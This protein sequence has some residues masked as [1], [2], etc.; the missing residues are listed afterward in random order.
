MTIGKAGTPYYIAPEIVNGRADITGIDRFVDVWALGMVF[1]ELLHGSPFFNGTTEE[2]VIKKIRT[3][4]YFIRNKEI[5]E[6]SFF[7]NTRFII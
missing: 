6:A 3:E 2:E 1:D 5:R 4:H 7:D